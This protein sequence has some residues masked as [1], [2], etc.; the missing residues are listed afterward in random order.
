[1][2][3][4][5]D[6]LTQLS[7]KHQFFG[8]NL[9]KNVEWV[10]SSQSLLIAKK[11]GLLFKSNNGVLS[12][13]ASAEINDS[14]KVLDF[15]L[16]DDF[17]LTFYIKNNE[18]YWSNLTPVNIPK[19]ETLF[20]SNEIINKEGSN[21]YLQ[22][23]AE[24]SV[25]D[26]IKYISDINK[27]S[28]K[29]LDPN[30]A[31]LSRIESK[32]ELLEYGLKSKHD[33]LYLDERL[34]DEGL[35]EIED[36]EGNLISFFLLK[37]KSPLDGICHLVFSPEWGGEYNIINS[38]WTW[39]SMAL[40]LNF[41][42]RETYWRYFFPKENLTHFEGVT[43]LSEDGNLAFNSGNEVEIHGDKM[44]V[45]YTSIEPIKLKQKMDVYFQLKKN[46]GIENRTEGIIINKLPTPAKETLYRVDEKGNRYSDIY[47]NF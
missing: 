42:T 11:L 29:H 2:I 43:I 21:F 23:K 27:L 35:Y 8:P 25:V 28:L 32:K 44:M 9:L 13:F 19:E 39:N 5:Y 30:S 45:C 26:S 36:K 31:K 7:I 20:F 12:V 17:S 47:I 4:S 46:V 38:D 10:P 16:Q 40:E 14:K 18:Q 41:P 34:L 33:E 6:I 37:D 15:R 3:L 24:V 1:M 22:N